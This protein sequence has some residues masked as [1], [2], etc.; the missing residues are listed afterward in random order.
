MVKRILLLCGLGVTSFLL[1]FAVSLYRQSHPIAEENL[2]GLAYSLQAAIENSAIHDPSLQALA[3]FHTP[4][5]A[6]FAL[7]DPRGVYVFHTNPDLIG[8][9]LHD[10]TI[11]KRLFAGQVSGNRV[12][13]ATGEEAYEFFS[14]IHLPT[15][16]LG[17]RLVLHTY[18]SDAVIRYA[19]ANLLALLTLLG[20]AWMLA[21]VIYRYALR[22]ERHLQEMEKRENMARMGEM[23][24]MLAHEIRNPLAGIKGFA[25]LIEKRPEDPR[26]KESAHRI[27]AEAKRLEALVSDLLAFARIEGLA[28]EPVEL[29]GL[30]E[31]T[32]ALLR[33]EAEQS[34][35]TMNLDCP[36]EL[37]VVA[38][39]DRLTQVLLN[40]ARNALQAM[41]EGGILNI[42]AQLAGPMAS[43]QIKDTGQGISPEILP[44]IFEPFFTTKARGTGLGLAL[45]KKIVEEHNG[46]ISVASGPGSGTTITVTLPARNDRG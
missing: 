9:E 11:L 16:A 42:Y 14:D 46:D 5:I 29:A 20:A 36:D 37:L 38:N 4:D 3:T 1:W 32:A 25:Q 45:C 10:K 43:I 26:T 21:A 15:Q 22:E 35:V 40:I 13:L 39:R 30:I 24:A 7:V 2:F 19:H 33:P 31:Q 27:V 41:P 28:M 8:T 12:R 23:G 34:N 17:L 6:Y 44:R 18:R